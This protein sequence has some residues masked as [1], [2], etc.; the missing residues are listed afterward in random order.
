MVR[1]MLGI[2]GVQLTL[3]ARPGGSRVTNLLMACAKFA[4]EA[5]SYGYEIHMDVR[6]GNGKISVETAEEA[7]MAAV[8][9]G[10]G[11]PWD[12]DPVHVEQHAADGGG[13]GPGGLQPG[14]GVGVR[15][16]GGGELCPSDARV[17]QADYH[18]A[19]RNRDPGDG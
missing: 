2:F 4:E 9:A 12:V 19:G 8:E 18:P 1:E 15:P 6:Y 11:G 14:G 7:V 16:G 5:R 3:L 17:R 10:D 13:A